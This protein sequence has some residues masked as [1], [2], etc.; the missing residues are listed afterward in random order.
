MNGCDRCGLEPT[1]FCQCYEYELET[2]I[3]F[4]EEELDKLT[5]VVNKITDYIKKEKD[6]R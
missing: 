1:D 2:R 3:I 6:V 4:L 5:E